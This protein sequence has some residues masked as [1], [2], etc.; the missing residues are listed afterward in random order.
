MRQNAP[1]G[2]K[3]LKTWHYF[4]YWGFTSFSALFQLHH[5]NSSLKDW[6]L[7]FGRDFANPWSATSKVKCY[8]LNQCKN[9]VT[10]RVQ[11]PINPNIV[12]FNF[13]NHEHFKMFSIFQVNIIPTSS[14]AIMPLIV[15]GVTSLSAG[16]LALMLPETRHS[17]LPDTIED[18][19]LQRK[20]KIRSSDLPLNPTCSIVESLRTKTND[21]TDK[22]IKDRPWEKE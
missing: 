13:F 17:Q 20:N 15:F 4:F 16:I 2:G 8:F 5:V 12:N 19:K 3:G 7:F 10:S 1:T 9:L 21:E 22:I 18:M 6:F 11:I 14:A